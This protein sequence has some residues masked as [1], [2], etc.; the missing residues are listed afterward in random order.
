MFFA[1]K[2]LEGIGIITKLDWTEE[3]W[4]AIDGAGCVVAVVTLLRA[5]SGDRSICSYT[6]YSNTRHVCRASW[7][8]GHREKVTGSGFQPRCTDF[9]WACNRGPLLAGARLVESSDRPIF[10]FVK[11]RSKDS[12]FVSYRTF[13]MVKRKM[14]WYSSIRD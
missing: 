11:G 1:E 5:H 6:L 13:S 2:T 12:S 7:Y 4:E 9:A 14:I 10:S 3:G 8:L